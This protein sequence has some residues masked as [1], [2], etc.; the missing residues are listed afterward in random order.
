VV[1]VAPGS[2]DRTR[3]LFVPDEVLA[4]ALR[5]SFLQHRS[6]ALRSVH[7]PSH[8]LAVAASWRPQLVVFRSQLEAAAAAHFCRALIA[9]AGTHGC[10]LLLITEA[11]QDADF[12]ELAAAGA[13]AHLVSPVEPPQLLA[14]IAELLALDRRAGPRVPVEALIH[15]EGFDADGAS[16]DATLSSALCVSEDGMVLESSRH[17]ALD[18][19]G[20]LHFFLPSAPERLSV[21]ARVRAAI[22]EIRLRYAVEFADLAPQHRAAIRRYVE[23]RRAAA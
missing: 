12:A 23:L 8:A 5:S 7:N 15:T 3:I 1:S 9:D 17:L 14:T 16:V 19:R 4:G 21:Q 22:D 11:L 13:D 20:R 10:K 6:V 2:G 18:A